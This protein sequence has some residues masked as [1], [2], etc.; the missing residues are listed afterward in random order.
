MI[1]FLGRKRL[2][3]TMVSMILMAPIVASTITMP[4]MIDKMFVVITYYAIGNPSAIWMSP[5]TVV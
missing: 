3:M 5:R 1:Y 2:T 4:T